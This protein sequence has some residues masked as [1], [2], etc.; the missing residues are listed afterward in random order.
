MILV[1]DSDSYSANDRIRGSIASRTQPVHVVGAG[2][3]VAFE[4]INVDELVV[5]GSPVVL[6]NVV[7]LDKE[8]EYEESDVE[9]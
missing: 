3:I 1:Q 8:L 6:I 5:K 9:L 4:E 2:V 7:L